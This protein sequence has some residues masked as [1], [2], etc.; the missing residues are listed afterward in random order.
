MQ[1]AYLV[2]LC[3]HLPETLLYNTETPVTKPAGGDRLFVATL[4]CCE[5]ITSPRTQEQLLCND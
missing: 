3:G 1:S 4:S 2:T 5:P